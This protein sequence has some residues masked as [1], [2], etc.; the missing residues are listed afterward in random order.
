MTGPVSGRL[1][2]VPI[3]GDSGCSWTTPVWV[4]AN[5][6]LVQGTLMVHRILSFPTANTTRKSVSSYVNQKQTRAT[7]TKKITTSDIPQRIGFREHLQDIMF[8]AQ[9][10]RILISLTPNSGSPSVPQRARATKGF[11]WNLSL[12][13]YQSGMLTNDWLITQPHGDVELCW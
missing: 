10:Y 7:H 5:G 6:T 4:L 12:I 3:R 9:N 2:I 11:L 13:R 8:Q 1:L